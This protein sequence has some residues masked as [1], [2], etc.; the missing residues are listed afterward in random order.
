[1]D[2]LCKL[3]HFILLR[4]VESSKSQTLQYHVAHTLAVF[5]TLSWDFFVSVNAHCLPAL[6]L[7]SFLYLENELYEKGDFSVDLLENFGGELVHWLG[8]DA[9]RDAWLGETAKLEP[10]LEFMC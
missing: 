10:V 9:G 1:M 7:D 6:L 8:S 3:A 2:P 4:I 5:E